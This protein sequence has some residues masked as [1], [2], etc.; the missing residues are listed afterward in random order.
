MATAWC[1][2]QNKHA[3][4]GFFALRLIQSRQYDLQHESQ[5]DAAASEREESNWGR[6]DGSYLDDSIAGC[7]YGPSC[8]QQILE[9][10]AG[11]MTRVSLARKRTHTCTHAHAN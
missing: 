7:T 3:G 4:Q 9:G 8:G 6:V 5:T 10:A 2:Q 11:L 1:S